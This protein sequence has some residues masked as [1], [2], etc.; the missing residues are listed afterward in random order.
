MKSGSTVCVTLEVSTLIVRF[1]AETAV[2][3]R[4][5]PSASGAT[6]LSCFSG[7]NWLQ[8]TWHFSANAEPFCPEHRS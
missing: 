5:R 1:V 3:S 7:F 2:A 6:I 4:A 8:H